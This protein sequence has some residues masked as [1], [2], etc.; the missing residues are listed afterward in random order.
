MTLVGLLSAG[1]RADA[2]PSVPPY[3]EVGRFGGF[4]ETANYTEASTAN[5]TEP[6]GRREP[7]E[8]KFV[9][10]IGMALNT[11]DA[12][13]PKKNG[14]A[15]YVLD[16][17]NPQALRA[18]NGEPGPVIGLKLEYRIQKL[19]SSGEVLASTQFTLAS[20]ASAPG[21]HAVSLAVDP[22]TDSVYV[23]L[24]DV[25]PAESNTGREAATYALESWPAGRREGEEQEALVASKRAVVAGPATLQP[26]G[27]S[28]LAQDTR[29]ESIAVDD[30]GAATGLAIAGEEYSG[31]GERTPVIERIATSGEHAG[32]IEATKWQGPADIEATEDAAAK[33]WGQSSAQIDAA[34]TNPDGSLNV[35]LGTHAEMPQSAD[36]EPNMAR[37]SGDLTQTTAI[38]P[39]AS[40]E[41]EAL[42]HDRAATIR[43]HQDEQ[44]NAP[45]YHSVTGNGGSREA[46]TLAPSVVQL[47]GE[48]G[49]PRELYAGIV[50]QQEPFRGGD[51]QSPSEKPYSWVFAQEQGEHHI[52]SVKPASLAIRIFDPQGESLGMIG[53]T[54]PGGP[55]NL[56]GGPYGEESGEKH[57]GS[58]VALAA[59]REGAL[60]A[61][62]Q[63]DLDE[64][65]EPFT[66]D[67]A[68]PIAKTIEP[69]L[70]RVQGDQVVEFAPG[71]GQGGAP[72]TEECPQP[73]GG[74][75]AANV[76]LPGS[77]SKGSAPVTVAA[78]ETLEFDA[79]EVNLQGG[80]PWA[81]EWESGDGASRTNAWVAENSWR[82]PA[83]TVEFTY[84]TPGT[85]TAKLR[86]V[87]DFGTLS[88]QRTVHVIPREPISEAKIAVVGSPVAGQLASLEAS[89]TFPQF[90]WP[91]DYHWS[92]GDGEGEDQPG[93][94]DQL[95]GQVQH[96][97]GAAGTYPVTLTIVDRRGET[98]KASAT[99]TVA[100]PPPGTGGAPHVVLPHAGLLSAGLPS[101]APTAA[102]PPRATG[103]SAVPKPLTRAQRLANALRVCRKKPR[104]LRASCERQ[105]RKKY[106]PRRP[107]R[108]ARKPGKRSPRKK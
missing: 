92:F 13:V 41:V 27:T 56:Q 95:A 74:F 107:S 15:I 57:W 30:V 53:D 90:D 49:F 38:L 20:S 66:I 45:A 58:F 32:S 72:G 1:D 14:Y 69:P 87:N 76:A 73:S 54:T 8:A 16:L 37:I 82:W 62:A 86:L 44:Q 83:P 85:Y 97:Y 33:F 40:A 48:G 79:S 80:A 24:A 99:V 65:R 63:P 17:V 96:V 75:S 91:V 81:Y 46:G 26:G 29:G 47:A 7:G 18:L 31:S 34:S 59:G 102:H 77:V 105:A 55:C 10:P 51:P 23:L 43:F 36:E 93:G 67:P 21:L 100:T 101:A 71:A 6:T 35:T 28:T 60:F 64:N 89:A 19:G 11:D 22:R 103:S 52:S 4:D 108:S 104:R 42:N 94:Q 70:E 5:L 68:A 9:Y 98:A 2:S 84:N 50:A 78:G 25:P 39:W 106:A 61:L 3:G 12:T 88:R